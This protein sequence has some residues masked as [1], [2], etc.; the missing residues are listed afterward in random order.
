M[1]DPPPPRPVRPSVPMLAALTGLTA[2]SIDMSLPAMPQL[3]RSFGAGVGAVQ[4][5]LS[6]FLVGFAAGQLVCGVV[7]DRVGRRPVLLGGL[8]LFALA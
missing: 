7:A 2:L 6:L 4:L 5:T 8:A 1:P 3:Q